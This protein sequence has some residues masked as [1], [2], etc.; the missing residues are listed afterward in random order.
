[1][2][3]ALVE[4]G[5]GGAIFREPRMMPLHHRPPDS[6]SLAMAAAGTPPC[7]DSPANVPDRHLGRRTALPSRCGVFE[8]GLCDAQCPAFEPPRWGPINA[9]ALPAPGAG[10]GAAG[11]VASAGMTTAPPLLEVSPAPPLVGWRHG[12]SRAHKARSRRRDVSFAHRSPARC[13]ASSASPAP[14]RP[15]VC[16]TYCASSRPHRRALLYR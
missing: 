13:W 10:G 14:A 2:R 15:T 3:A 6:V 5:P 1:M 8:P 4:A 7:G 16:R 9:R 11:R 12:G